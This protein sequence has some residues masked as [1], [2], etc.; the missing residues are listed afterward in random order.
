MALSMNK[1]AQAILEEHFHLSRLYQSCYFSDT[2][3]R[4]V[5]WIALHG[6]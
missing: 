2:K 3:H 6:T 5:S 4:H 1:T